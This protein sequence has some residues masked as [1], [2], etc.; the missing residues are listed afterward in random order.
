MDGPVTTGGHGTNM[1]MEVVVDVHSNEG[2]EERMD[3]RRLLDANK[4]F[5]N[6][7][8]FTTFFGIFKLT[9]INPISFSSQ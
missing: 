4:E 6:E 3:G 7:E 1:E 8:N 9:K 5:E 2:P